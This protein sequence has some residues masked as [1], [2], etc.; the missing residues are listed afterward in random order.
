LTELCQKEET[1]V[2]DSDLYIGDG[3]LRVQ[4]L[5]DQKNDQGKSLIMEHFVEFVKV[6]IIVLVH[7]TT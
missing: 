6:D 3:H 2:G 1:L 4:W 7:S 5:I